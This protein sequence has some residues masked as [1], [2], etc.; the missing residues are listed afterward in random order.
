MRKNKALIGL[1]LLWWGIFTTWAENV[2]SKHLDMSDELSRYSVMALYQEEKGRNWMCTE[3]NGSFRLEPKTGNTPWYLT[4]IAY[5]C[6]ILLSIVLLAL[7]FHSYKNRI[8][9][10]TEL[11]YERKH[12]EEVEKMNQY[13]LRFFTNISH[14]FR[15][16]LSVIIGQIDSLLQVRPCLP[17]VYKR[18]LSIYNSGIQLQTLINELLDFQ[19]QES[20]YMK[21]RVRHGDM[22]AFL[23]ESFHVFEEYAHKNEVRLRLITSEE[24]INMWFDSKQMQKVI[25]NL[26][27]N[28]IR[29]TPKGGVVTLII[30]KNVD[31]VS[32]S[33]K[34]TGK[35]IKPEDLTHIFESFYQSRDAIEGTGIGL[36]LVKGI[37]ELHGGTISVESKEGEGSIFTFCLPLECVHYGQ[38]EMGEEEQPM[39]IEHIDGSQWADAALIQDTDNQE[40]K[41]SKPV[42]KLLI[43]ED[44]EELRTM[45]VDIFSPLY[46]V[47]LAFNG[48]EGWNKT[49]DFQPDIILSDVLIPLMSGIEL[50]RRLKTNVATSHIP[51]V[52]LTART[53]IE[54]EL[55]GLRYG[56]N[57]Y[58]V[59]PFNVN[60][61]LAKCRNLINLRIAIQEQLTGEPQTTAQLAPSSL[62]QEFM[63]KA[64][65]VVMDNLANPEFNISVFI[66][67]MGVCRTLLFNKLKAVTGQ[68]PNDF[69]TTIRLKEAACF[70]KNHPE[71]N[72][73]EISEKTGFNSVGYFGRVFKERYK[74]T[75]SDYRLRE[76]AKE[77]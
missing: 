9:L 48:Q 71:W 13:K 17:F 74:V 21:I 75:P 5:L 36:A 32:V 51:I 11:E 55:E 35:G 56:A 38:E 62:D 53:S 29:Y 40:R 15:T 60:I 64:R 18:L 43:V 12:L 61:L 42:F 58:I 59:K 49:M 30:N 63:D 24:T 25:N 76:K 44:D 28:A 47:E 68:S 69:V 73:T 46:L 3:E 27:S 45:L 57:D 1:L 22:V 34:D 14:E 10:Q 50:C 31:K 65:D 4:R 7:L 72:V 54:H 70:L 39:L 33:V 19:K 67:E 16:P 37:V 52:L 8:R 26:L 20:G 6:Y 77:H 66:Q 2:I 23:K 41:G